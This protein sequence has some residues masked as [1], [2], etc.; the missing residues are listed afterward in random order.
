MQAKRK[1]VV[2]WGKPDRV[3]EGS[4]Q[5]SAAVRAWSVADDG[6]DAS[7]AMERPHKD[8]PT[9]TFQ[10][11]PVGMIETDELE[12]PR[13]ECLPP[14]P[15]PCPCA[16][17]LTYALIRVCWAWALEQQ[18]RTGSGRFAADKCHR[19]ALAATDAKAETT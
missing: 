5:P 19:A 15:L 13:S 7:S 3:K 6:R 10:L 12:P 1:P 18:P 4:R 17:V 16:V 11:M 14:S 8:N 2:R 9:S